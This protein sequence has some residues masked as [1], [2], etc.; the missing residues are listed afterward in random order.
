MKKYNFNGFD[1]TYDRFL[2][3][4]YL[5]DKKLQICQV[6]VMLGGMLDWF[7][8]VM[9]QTT[10]SRDVKKT[11]IRCKRNIYHVMHFQSSQRR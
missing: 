1:S 4:R 5:D 2:R 3:I 8:S 10:E 7:S 6:C 9:P 11:L